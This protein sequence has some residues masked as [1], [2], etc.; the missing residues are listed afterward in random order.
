MLNH[1]LFKMILGHLM[2]PSIIEYVNG[3]MFTIV[4]L[5]VHMVLVS[6]FSF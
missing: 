1:N 6:Q 2:P 5:C 4:F 3:I